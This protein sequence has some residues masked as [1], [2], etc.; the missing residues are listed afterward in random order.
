MELRGCQQEKGEGERAQ[1][2]LILVRHK[3][4]FW[5]ERIQSPVDMSGMD[6]E[7]NLRFD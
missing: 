1:R 4:A 5:G 3:K 7:F 2:A 6:G